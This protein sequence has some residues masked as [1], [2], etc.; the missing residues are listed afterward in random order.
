MAETL[1]PAAALV[2]RPSEVTRN[3]TKIL[4]EGLPRELRDTICSHIWD[5]ETIQS[6]RSSPDEPKH[7]Q[8]ID[9]IHL[10]YAREV[11]QW[12]YENTVSLHITLPSD[13]SRFFHRDTFG[14]GVTPVHCRL[15][16]VIVHIPIRY[17]KALPISRY[18]DIEALHGDFQVLLNADFRTGTS[19]HILIEADPGRLAPIFWLRKIGRCMS[20]VVKEL[21]AK[22]AQLS[23]EYRNGWFKK[24]VRDLM[25]A[26]KEAWSDIH[27]HDVVAAATMRYNYARFKYNMAKHEAA[28]ETFEEEMIA[29]R[30][31]VLQVE[32]SLARDEC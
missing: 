24:D 11:V 5:D 28:T 12:Y 7:A 14:V 32:T 25:G 30:E 21:A 16:N 10:H 20:P 23:I 1:R 6:V 15:R 22:G 17:I 3:L 29:W 2:S 27:N 18:K 19:I 31:R 8:F 4:Y 26:P 9:A 13:I